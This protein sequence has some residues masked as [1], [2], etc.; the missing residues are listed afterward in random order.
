MADAID[1][2]ISLLESE[3]AQLDKA[4]DALRSVREA[5]NGSGPVANSARSSVPPKPLS[6]DNTNEEAVDTVLSVTGGGLTTS[7][8]VD[9]A[10]ELGKEVKKN[11]IRWTLSH[12][13]DEGKYRKK[14]QE[15]GRANLYWLIENG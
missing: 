8:I 13:V 10:A 2:A 7:E 5:R 4:L 14:K 6:E 1:Q 15:N 3:R 12:G 9:K 11:S